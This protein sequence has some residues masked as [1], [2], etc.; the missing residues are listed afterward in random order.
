MQRRV[1][2]PSDTVSSWTNRRKDLRVIRPAAATAGFCFSAE[3]G[4]NTGCTLID[5]FSPSNVSLV[6]LKKLSF[7]APNP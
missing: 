7:V 4:S 6:E 1:D 2:S 3:N 5:E